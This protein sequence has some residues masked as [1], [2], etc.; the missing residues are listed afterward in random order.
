MQ[1]ISI[2]GLG[3]FAGGEYGKVNIDGVSSCGGDIVCESIAVDGAFHCGG[4]IR[5]KSASADGTMNVSGDMTA[6]TFGIDGAVSIQG[7]LHAPKLSVDGSCSVKGELH[8]ERLDIDGA[9]NV[10]QNVHAQKISVDGSLSV[11]GTVETDTLAVDGS[12]NLAALQ[13]KQFNCD[14]SAHIAECFCAEKITIDGTMQTDGN[15]EAETLYVDGCLSAKKQISADRV[16]IYGTVQADEIVGDYI[17]I[18]F[19]SS[20]RTIRQ[21]KDYVNSFVNNLLNREPEVRECCANLIEATTVELYGVTAGVVSGENVEI[22]ENCCIDRLECTGTYSID[23]SSYV[24][25]INGQPYI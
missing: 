9:V 15:L 7:D 20:P 6:E 5:A 25:V 13:A 1:N 14:G 11:Q 24:R 23:P 12:V 22:G 8:T 18:E 16:E 19:D 17:R 3:N 2:E 21:I 10:Q 4:S